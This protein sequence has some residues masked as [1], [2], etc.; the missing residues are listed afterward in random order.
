M[1]RGARSVAVRVAPAAATSERAA[2][3]R[4]LRAELAAAAVGRGAMRTY[5]RGERVL[6][7]GTCEEV[8][9]MVLEGIVHKVWGGVRVIYRGMGQGAGSLQRVRT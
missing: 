7:A 1:T 3:H 2:A 8:L 9:L 4:R 6:E 5:R